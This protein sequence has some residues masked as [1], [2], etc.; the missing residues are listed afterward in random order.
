MLKPGF[1]ALLEDPF[2]TKLLDIIIFNVLPVSNKDGEAWAFVANEL[3]D[4][5]PLRYAFSVNLC[6]LT[7]F[8]NIDLLVG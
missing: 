3:K 7:C 8:L 4:R 5:N 1:L 6:L 2:G